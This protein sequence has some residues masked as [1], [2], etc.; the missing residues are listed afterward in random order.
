M[1]RKTVF[2]KAIDEYVEAQ[3]ANADRPE[4]HLNIGLL[5]TQIGRFSEAETEYQTAIKLQPSFRHM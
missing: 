3:L 5:Y 1:V 4:A 2:E